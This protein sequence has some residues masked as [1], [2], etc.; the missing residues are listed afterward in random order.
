MSGRIHRWFLRGRLMRQVATGV[1]LSWLAGIGLAAFVIAHEMSKLMD[2]T[3]TGSAR[4][5]LA[6]HRGSGVV[7]E[8]AADAA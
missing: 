5:S 8:I 2:Q 6:F 3:L 7:G 1:C 4:L